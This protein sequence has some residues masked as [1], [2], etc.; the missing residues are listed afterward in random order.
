MDP[1]DNI[2]VTIEDEAYVVVKMA[3]VPEI[4]DISPSTSGKSMIFAKTPG[5][6]PVRVGGRT[7]RLNVQLYAP[8]KRKP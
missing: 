7:L 3:A 8:R 1:V 5:A 4:V 2:E 6:L